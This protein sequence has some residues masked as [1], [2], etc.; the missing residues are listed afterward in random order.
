MGFL[1]P[2]ATLYVGYSTVLVALDSPSGCEEEEEDN[3]H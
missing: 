3:A 2:S 1:Y